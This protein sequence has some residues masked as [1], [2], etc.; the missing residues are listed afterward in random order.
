MPMEL[1]HEYLLQLSGNRLLL[2][3]DRPE[4]TMHQWA[5]MGHNHAAYELH[6]L[7]EGACRVDV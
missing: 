2:R 6:M 3:M 5:G 7:L 1:S 4:R